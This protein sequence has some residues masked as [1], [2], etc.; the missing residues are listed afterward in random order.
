MPSFNLIDA[1]MT[2]SLKRKQ[3]IIHL[4][5]YIRVWPSG[6]DGQHTEANI[7]HIESAQSG[8]PENVLRK[9]EGSRVFVG[10]P[11]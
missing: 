9:R 5:C 1:P 3:L 2:F 6:S 8:S 4:E 10:W 11:L 7:A